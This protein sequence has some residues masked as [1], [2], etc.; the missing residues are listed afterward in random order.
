MKAN[1]FPRAARLRDRIAKLQIAEMCC[2]VKIGRGNPYRRC[3]FC[4]ATNVEVNRTD[5]GHNHPCRFRGI[6]KEIAHYQRLLA[7]ETNA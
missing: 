7:E 2:W 6:E 3:K 1:R 4:N 5:G